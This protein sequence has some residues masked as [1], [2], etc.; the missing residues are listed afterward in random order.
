MAKALRT[1]HSSKLPAEVKREILCIIHNSFH[2]IKGDTYLN[3]VRNLSHGLL[4]KDSK[5]QNKQHN[6]SKACIYFHHF[7]RTSIKSQP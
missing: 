1:K 3:S 6:N 2:L 5:E 4:Y 7:K